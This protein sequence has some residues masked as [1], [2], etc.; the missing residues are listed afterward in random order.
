MINKIF[1]A[2]PRKEILQTKEVFVIKK[3]YLETNQLGK[4]INNTE[5]NFTTERKILKLFKC[6]L[7]LFKSNLDLTMLFFFLAFRTELKT[8][9]HNLYTTENFI[10]IPSTQNLMTGDSQMYYISHDI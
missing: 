10:M 4:F 6:Y 2:N 9:R 3:N 7:T 8:I 5:I 1:K